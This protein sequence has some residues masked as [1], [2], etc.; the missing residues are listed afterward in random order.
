MGNSTVTFR[1]L[2]AIWMRPIGPSF[3][4]MLSAFCVLMTDFRPLRN[5]YIA[6]ELWTAR[7]MCA[8]ASSL[9][10]CIASCCVGGGCSCSFATLKSNVADSYCGLLTCCL[11]M[12]LSCCIVKT[13]WYPRLRS[14]KKIIFL[15]VHYF[16]KV[17]V[18][19]S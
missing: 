19:Q 13:F 1:P 18:Y 8:V 14:G 4:K 16:R 7:G 12:Q 5:W 9:S 2:F 10:F 6:C 17:Q 11:L 15:F 3:L